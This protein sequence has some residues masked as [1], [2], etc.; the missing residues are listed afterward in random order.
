MKLPDVGED[1]LWKPAPKQA[2]LLSAIDLEVLYGGA[3]G[4]G[5]SDCLLIDAL[6]LQQGAIDNRNYQAILFRRTFPDLRD[7]ID[8]SQDLYPAFGGKYD[9]THHIWTFPSG[10]RVEFGHMQYDSDRFKYRGRAFQYIGWDELTLFPTDIPYRYMLSRLRSKDPAIT[11]Y[12]R[13]TTNP[14]GPGFRWVKEYFRIQTEGTSTRFKVSV[15]DPETGEVHEHGRRFISARLSDNPHLADSG[16]RQT[17]LLLS[18]EEQRA[19]LMGRWE[20]PNIRG[21]YYAEQME[22][23]R[24]EGRIR[25]IPRL[26][27][28]P[29]NTFWDLGWNDTTAV[30]FHQRVG[31]EHR[32]ID[33]MEASGKDLQFFASEIQGRGYTYARHYLP[34]D[35]DNKTLASGGKSVRMLLQGLLPAHRFEVV[36][37]TDSL[38]SAINQ[39]RAVIP[40]CYFDEDRTAN[41]IAGLEAYRREWDEKLGDF[42][43]EPLHDWASNPADAFRQFAQGYREIYKGGKKPT[44]WRDRLKAH[45]ARN[46]SAQAA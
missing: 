12:V 1:I 6:G 11:C 17:L 38:V 43:Q 16:Y 34:H 24:L 19:L 15:T 40:S 13:A 5:K 14:D 3:A 46:R 36:P 4:A 21:A 18:A 29:V 9:K 32:F 7:L 35:A 27:H 31:M 39:T 42:K 20:T 10:A 30:W 45:A 8:R 28:V 22:A 25:K 41:G 33:Y 37:R 23:A 2:I 44:S 26:P